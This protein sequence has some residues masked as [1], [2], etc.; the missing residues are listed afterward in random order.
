MDGGCADESV[1]GFGAV[2]DLREDALECGFFED[3]RVKLKEGC[4]G[5]EGVFWRA[6]KGFLDRWQ[7]VRLEGIGADVGRDKVLE[8]RLYSGGMSRL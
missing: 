4:N 6:K 1:A 2:D 5:R 8:G 7:V 3:V